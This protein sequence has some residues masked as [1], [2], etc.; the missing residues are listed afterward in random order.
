MLERLKFSSPKSQMQTI[1]PAVSGEP[2]DPHCWR[3]HVSIWLGFLM[4]ESLKS[5]VSSLRG[6]E[7]RAVGLM[8]EDLQSAISMYL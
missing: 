5:E 7:E 8:P 3:V 1:R 2:E 6:C 4:L